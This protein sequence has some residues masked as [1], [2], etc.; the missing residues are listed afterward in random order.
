L[1]QIAAMPLWFMQNRGQPGMKN[2][3]VIREKMICLQLARPNVFKDIW[4]YLQM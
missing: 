4:H 2:R 3:P 1:K